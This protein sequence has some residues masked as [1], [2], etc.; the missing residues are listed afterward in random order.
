[1]ASTDPLPPMTRPELRGSKRAIT[2]EQL[3]DELEVDVLG[4]DADLDNVLFPVMS[5]EWDGGEPNDEQLVDVLY[6]NT[7]T[8][9]RSMRKRLIDTLW[10]PDY[11]KRPPSALSKSAPDS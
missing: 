11:V 5:I 4:R 7:F 8:T 3:A 9:S 10:A 2:I 1:M 6:E